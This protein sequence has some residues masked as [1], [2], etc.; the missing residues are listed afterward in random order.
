[1]DL[2]SGLTVT[3]QDVSMTDLL[4]TGKLPPAFADFAEKANKEGNA[5]IDLKELMA[6]AADFTKMLD[7]L[8]VLA[9]VEPKLG[10]F[11]DDETITL[12]E[13]PSDDKMAIF[14]WV[15]REVTQL[16]SFREG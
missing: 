14:N 12:A 16:T 1:M 8:V 15:N 13:I 5:S 10:E 4:L 2:P 7:T 6:N 9:L 3:V 11:A